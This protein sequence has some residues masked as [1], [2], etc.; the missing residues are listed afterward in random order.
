MSE[1]S[2]LRRLSVC[3]NT[4]HAWPANTGQ[5]TGKSP[6]AQ[7][8][9]HHVPFLWRVALERVNSEVAQQLGGNWFKPRAEIYHYTLVPLAAQVQGRYGR[10]GGGDIARPCSGGAQ[11]THRACGVAA[12]LDTDPQ[13]AAIMAAALVEAH[14]EC[15]GC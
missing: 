13:V 11:C 7:R 2:S 9:F 10:G 1:A 12:L 15:D 4:P 3:H 6:T 5:L 8:H 14:R